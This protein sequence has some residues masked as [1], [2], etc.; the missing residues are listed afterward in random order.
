[1]GTAHSAITAC[2]ARG[3]GKRPSIIGMS[4]DVTELKRKERDLAEHHRILQT[5]IEIIPDGLQVLGG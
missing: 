2:T 5:A 1:M 3:Q 4:V